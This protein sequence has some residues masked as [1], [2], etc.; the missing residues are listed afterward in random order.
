MST[1]S[2][3]AGSSGGGLVG[4][5]CI[6]CN[7]ATYCMTSDNQSAIAF[8]FNQ[9]AC[10][11]LPDAT[12][13]DTGAA[14]Y[15]M[16][17]INSDSNITV[18]DYCSRPFTILTP[19]QSLQ[20][21]LYDNS[22]V[23]G[24][25]IHEKPTTNLGGVGVALSV[26]IICDNYD[27]H[28]TAC[29]DCNKTA[30][31]GYKCATC[32]FVA[33]VGK[34]DTSSETYTFTTPC[35]V[36]TCNTLSHNGTS[37][38]YG[39]CSD[40]DFAVWVSNKEGPQIVINKDG[41]ICMC[42]MTD[43]C[44]KCWGTRGWG[45][46]T[47]YIDRFL[48]LNPLCAVSTL[49]YQFGFGCICLCTGVMCMYDN[50]CICECL[51]TGL[52]YACIGC[53]V[54]CTQLCHFNGTVHCRINTTILSPAC[55]NGGTSPSCNQGCR[56]VDVVAV[57]V[58]NDG[59]ATDSY[60]IYRKLT[61]LGRTYCSCYQ[62]Y[63]NCIFC[64]CMCTTACFKI[65]FPGT[66]C[67]F[68]L[69]YHTIRYDTAGIYCCFTSAMHVNGT[70]GHGICCACI[71]SSQPFGCRACLHDNIWPISE[72]Y[73]IHDIYNGGDVD[74]KL[75]YSTYNGS[76][77]IKCCLRLRCDTTGGQ[78]GPTTRRCLFDSA[79]ACHIGSPNLMATQA[80]YR[81][82]F[83][84][85]KYHDKDNAL[86]TS[87]YCPLINANQGDQTHK[88]GMT[89]WTK[90]TSATCGCFTFPWNAC[91]ECNCA[92][93]FT[94]CWSGSTLTQATTVSPCNFGDPFRNSLFRVTSA[95]DF[96]Y[97]NLCCGT[98]GCFRNNTTCCNV[99]MDC[100]S[101]S[102]ANFV[103][104][105][106]GFKYL[107]LSCDCYA[108]CICRDSNCCLIPTGSAG[109]PVTSLGADTG[110][111]INNAR[112]TPASSSCGTSIAYQNACNAF[113]PTVTTLTFNCT[114]L[115]FDGKKCFNLDTIPISQE[116]RNMTGEAGG[117]ILT[118]TDN[119]TRAYSFLTVNP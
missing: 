57:R 68:N 98:V 113:L 3:F 89:T 27:L 53:F 36:T 63:N 62:P 22:D 107:F 64:Q 9:T 58:P 15:T 75:V 45:H 56:T 47:D 24:K 28:C 12:S 26:D 96:E 6:T 97:V 41:G 4:G 99:V 112:V 49:C 33:S 37:I 13:L 19:C 109:G 10:V 117:Y 92:T 110:V 11:F 74:A 25:W 18:Y 8:C 30:V 44:T 95:G 17:N 54:N 111:T 87:K 106:S 31:W 83:C 86:S 88:N 60:C 104:I 103:P 65:N 100:C 32:L 35:C 39:S 2:T 115:K 70:T 84:N 80:Y 59:A 90:R 1:Y 77:T 78:C 38:Y 46:R 76:K 69:Y 119:C 94:F 118:V 48:F 82:R 42:C 108:V 50:Q 67:C 73:Y 105:D 91:I 29:I 51:F 61:D 72:N 43:S 102:S 14:K 66:A 34:F 101:S 7:G 93:Y 21:S 55:A 114:D 23:C 79:V 71:C 52:D 40:D 81:S 116:R 5:E 16:K 20:V 85:T